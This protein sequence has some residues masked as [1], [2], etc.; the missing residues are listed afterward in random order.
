MSQYSGCKAD[1][2]SLNLNLDFVLFF[3]GVGGEGEGLV[4]F[5]I[6]ISNKIVYS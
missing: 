5:F 6:E 4:S 3:A 2:W 1:I